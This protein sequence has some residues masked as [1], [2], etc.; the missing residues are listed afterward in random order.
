MVF[1]LEVSDLES[2]GPIEMFSVLCRMLH[3]PTGAC[4]VVANGSKDSVHYCS[5]ERLR[6]FVSEPSKL[7]V[8]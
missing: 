3:F 7:T 6:K 1:G 8:S 5:S 4:N 2:S